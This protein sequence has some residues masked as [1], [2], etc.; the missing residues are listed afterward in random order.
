MPVVTLPEAA[1]LGTGSMCIAHFLNKLSKSYV[2]AG[3]QFLVWLLRICTPLQDQQVPNKPEQD[4]G[5]SG[6]R[7]NCLQLLGVFWW[8]NCSQQCFKHT[9]GKDCRGGL[10]VLQ[11]SKS[12]RQ[13][14]GKALML[15]CTLPLQAVKSKGRSLSAKFYQKDG[16]TV[17]QLHRPYHHT[18]CSGTKNRTC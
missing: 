13:I 14:E 10:Q 17:I 1:G 4:Q 16:S 6:S 11:W 7:K 2:V 5:L 3:L 18:A 8:H 12:A 9:I 15:L